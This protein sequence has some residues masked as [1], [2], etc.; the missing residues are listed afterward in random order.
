MAPMASFEL[1]LLFMLASS[2]G[3]YDTPGVRNARASGSLPRL[4]P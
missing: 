3:V 2:N 1:S 4:L